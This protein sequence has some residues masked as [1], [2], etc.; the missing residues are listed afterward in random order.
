MRIPRPKLTR[1]EWISL[2]SFLGILLLVCGFI[3]WASYEIRDLKSQ[4]QVSRSTVYAPR[5]GRDGVDGTT[6]I[7]TR[8]VEIPAPKAQDGIDGR[9][10]KDV[11]ADQIAQAVGDYMTKNPVKDGK[12]GQDGKDGYV[13]WLRLNP[14]T[15]IPECRIQN[16]LL[17]LPVEECR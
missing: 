13:I 5:D 9:D 14:L 7:I 6:T 10:G 3:A 4:I 11:T 2:L 12:D 17:W 1:Q 16:T 8:N 15:L